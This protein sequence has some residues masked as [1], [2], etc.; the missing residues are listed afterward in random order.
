[1]TDVTLADSILEKSGLFCVGIETNFAGEMLCPDNRYLNT[2]LGDLFAGWNHVGGTSFPA[3]LR[4]EGDVRMY[5]WKDLANVNS[6]TLIKS[7]VGSTG[8]IQLK[9]DLAAMIDYMNAN[10]KDKI[11]SIVEQSDDTKYVHGGIAL[12]GG[13]RNYSQVDTSGLKDDRK[14]GLKNFAINLSEVAGSG[15]GEDITQLL[16][17][18]AGTQDFR[19]F[20]YEYTGSNDR[21]WQDN[22]NYDV[23][24]VSFG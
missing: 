19:F 2:E 3:I 14:S 12:Y 17:R 7:D 21:A 22:A 24:A 8:G 18:A 4:L 11:G 1:M 6:D 9:L 16:P 10:A 20:M 13:G 15:D 5:D 23:P